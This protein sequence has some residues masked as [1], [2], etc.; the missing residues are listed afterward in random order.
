MYI[1]HCTA[2]T[3][4][5]VQEEEGVLYLNTEATT[6]AT[7]MTTTW[8]GHRSHEFQPTRVADPYVF[9]GSTDPDPYS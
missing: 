3:V 4:Y 9:A 2:Y 5:I 7:N 1:V 6:D 8:G